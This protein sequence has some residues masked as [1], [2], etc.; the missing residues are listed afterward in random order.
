VNR[1][2]AKAS[3]MRSAKSS[4]NRAAAKASAMHSAERRVSRAAPKRNPAEINIGKFTYFLIPCPRGF[5][6]DIMKKVN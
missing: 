4:V 3:A 2:A 6:Y 5:S 1:A